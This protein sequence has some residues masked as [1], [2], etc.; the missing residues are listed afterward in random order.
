MAYLIKTPCGIVQGTKSSI[1]GAVAFKGIR[2]ATA[3][4]WE[5]PQLVTSWEGVYDASQ[6]GPCCWQNRAFESEEGNFYYREFR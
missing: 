1:P 4:R 2:Y 3:G 6:Y 5:Y